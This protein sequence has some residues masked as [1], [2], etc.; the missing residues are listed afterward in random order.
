MTFWNVRML[1]MLL[2]IWFKFARKKNIIYIKNIEKNIL[3]Y[4]V[5]EHFI[6]ILLVLINTNFKLYYNL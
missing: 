3:N 4:N 5:F 6:G 1:G 2:K